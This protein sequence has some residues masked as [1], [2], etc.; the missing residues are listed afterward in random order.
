M[1]T[2]L[3]TDDI[4]QIVQAVIEALKPLLLKKNDKTEDVILDVGG[5]AEYLGVD[6]SWVYKAVSQKSIPYY[7]IGKY[8]KFR[9]AAIDKWVETQ[10]VRPVSHLASLRKL[11]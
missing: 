4:V 6:R 9:Q 10:A 2:K 3:E 8:T 1:Q 7:K 5:L 11:S